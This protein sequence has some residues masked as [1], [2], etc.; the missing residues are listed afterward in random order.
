MAHRKP[1]RMLFMYTKVLST[2]AFGQK[3]HV[4]HSSG[5]S[6]RWIDEKEENQKWR[7]IYPNSEVKIYSSELM[8]KNQNVKINVFYCEGLTQYKLENPNVVMGQEDY[9]NPNLL[10]GEFGKDSNRNFWYRG[11]HPSH[12]EQIIQNGIEEEKE[13]FAV[14]RSDKN[15]CLEYG[16][17]KDLD[18]EDFGKLITIYEPAAFKEDPK[19]WYKVYPIGKSVISPIC[20]V[21]IFSSHE[22]SENFMQ[23]LNQHS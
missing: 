23:E 19:D 22:Q 5:Q 11:T 4:H 1:L 18:F 2:P 8:I 17:G 3:S 9:N 12:I 15:K 21:G 14:R 20:I 16:N 13:Y 6:M 10:I 7:K